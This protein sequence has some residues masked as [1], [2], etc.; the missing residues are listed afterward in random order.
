MKPSKNSPNL[1]SGQIRA[2][3]SEQMSASL[4]SACETVF[5]D[6]QSNCS[7]FSDCHATVEHHVSPFVH[8]LG[9]FREVCRRVSWR[10]E[11]SVAFRS[12]SNSPKVSPFSILA[13]KSGLLRM[14]EVEGCRPRFLL[15]RWK[16]LV[17]GAWLIL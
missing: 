5:R 15:C 17:G 14:E 6:V 2:S 7:H 16:S 13:I 9:P 11:G 8:D 4:H 12:F 3:W 10:V 1:V